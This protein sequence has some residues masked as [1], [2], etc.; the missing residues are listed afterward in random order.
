MKMKAF[1]M[2]GVIGLLMFSFTSFAMAT[3]GGMSNI[4]P[5]F[6]QGDSSTATREFLEL[7]KSGRLWIARPSK[8]GVVAMVTLYAPGLEEGHIILRELTTSEGHMTLLLTAPDMVRI[9]V[10]RVTV[11]TRGLSETVTLLEQ[12]NGKWQ[13]RL[14]QSL[15][16]DAV[17]DGSLSPQSLR[18]FSVETLGFYWLLEP[19][20][21]AS[22]A[23]ST[24][25]KT[26]AQT[27][28]GGQITWGFMPSMFG[29]MLLIFFGTLSRY[30]HKI[31]KLREF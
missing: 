7:E 9:H 4:G 28:I 19:A 22:P 18:V 6:T 5:I 23:M 26:S 27:L 10:Q 30:I 2:G 11:Y 3:M 25:V 13:K 8:F 21:I 29:I 16:I 20:S 17:I 24:S 12:V 31:S 15:M 1:K 14:P